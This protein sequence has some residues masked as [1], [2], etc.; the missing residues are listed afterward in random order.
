MVYQKKPISWLGATG[1]KEKDK[2]IIIVSVFISEENL[3][4]HKNQRSKTS[5][6]K[7][8]SVPILLR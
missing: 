7:S 3:S 4:T 6:R 1:I 2:R 5:R 8:L